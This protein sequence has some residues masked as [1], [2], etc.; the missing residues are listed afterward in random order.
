[1]TILDYEGQ[2]SVET[3]DKERIATLTRKGWL[4]RP[5]RPQCGDNQTVEWDGKQ[6]RI[7]TLQPPAVDRV[8]T[9]A[10]LIVLR[11]RGLREQ[12]DTVCASLPP[13]QQE[14]VKEMLQM[15]YTRR[16][17]PLIAMVQ[18]AFGWTDAEVDALFAEA[19]AV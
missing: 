15:P 1:M 16:D 3:D 4:A 6:W 12:F 7:V 2:P 8:A 18:Q 10:L 19:D 9:A 5:Q 11:K 14:Y 13:E 17:H